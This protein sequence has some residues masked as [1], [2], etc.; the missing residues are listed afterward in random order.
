MATRK[1]TTSRK[2]SARTGVTPKISDEA[3]AAKT[4]KTWK[5]WFGVL[6]RAG[7]RRKTHQQIVAVL[8]KKYRVGMWWQQ[9]VAVSYEQAKGLRARHEKPEG[10]Q[11]TRSKTIGASVDDVFEAW[12]NTRRRAQWLPGSKL[13]IRKATE[14][15]SL[16]ITWGDGTMIEVGL[17]PKAGA[18]TQVAV[19]HGKLPTARAAAAQKAFWGEALDRLAQLLSV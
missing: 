8:S 13:T 7:A 18:K 14:N 4:G 3:V 6:D 12:G 2:P 9:M 1:T 5:Q 19:Q 10:F 17:F 11:I 15:K 16:R